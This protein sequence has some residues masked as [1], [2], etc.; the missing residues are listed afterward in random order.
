M[1]SIVYDRRVSTHLIKNI[2]RQVVKCDITP[3]RIGPRTPEQPSVMPMR[4]EM[5]AILSGAIS[6]ISMNVIE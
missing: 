2:Q 3:P 5:P 4:P 1:V 6:G